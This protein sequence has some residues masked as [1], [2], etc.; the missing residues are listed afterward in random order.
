MLSSPLGR[1]LVVV[2]LGG[3]AITNKAINETL[4]AEIFALVCDHLHRAVS[5][6]GPAPHLLV[7]HGAGSFGHLSA[8][9]YGLSTGGSLADERLLRGF[10]IT[11]G[12]VRK[13]NTIVVTALCARGLPALGVS[14]FDHNWSTADKISI[15]DAGASLAASAARLLSL[16]F[17][18]VV[19]PVRLKKRDYLQLLILPAGRHL[20][21]VGAGRCQFPPLR[22]TKLMKARVLL[23]GYR[24]SF[25]SGRRLRHIAGSRHPIRRHHRQR[26]EHPAKPHAGRLLH[27]RGRRLRPS[28]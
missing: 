27:E 9:E 8:R 1:P 12:A 15:T 16:G 17:T 22:S 23:S 10:A 3:A 20:G 21:V 2:K 13:L 11:R 7:V 25:L 4:N 19:H 24:P 28:A 5:A 26:F 14:P 18:P 6:S